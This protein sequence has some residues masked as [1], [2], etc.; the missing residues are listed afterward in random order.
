ML[1]KKNFIKLILQIR[2]PLGIKVKK[3]FYKLN[4]QSLIKILNN[5]LFLLIQSNQHIIKVK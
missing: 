5:I 3:S 1:Y 4:E 2:M